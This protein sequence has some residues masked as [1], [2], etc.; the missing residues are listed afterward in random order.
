MTPKHE[1]KP[2]EDKLHKDNLNACV[3]CGFCLPA[4][5]TYLETGSEADSPRGRIVLMRGLHE[6]TLLPTDPDVVRHLDLCLGCRACEPACPSGVQ[7][8]H[9]LEYTRAQLHREHARPAQTEAARRAL[10]GV[11]T[12]PKAATIAMRFAQIGTGGQVPAL[13]V[14]ALSGD[15][16][17]Q[18]QTTTL[19]R[20]ISPP[21]PRVVTQAVG[22]RRYRVGLLTGCVMRVLYGDVNK[23]TVQVLAANGCEVLANRRQGCCGA[24]HAHQGQMGEAQAMARAL[25]DAFSP[26]GGL[27]A[28]IVNS[29]GCGSAMKAYGMLLAGDP[30]YATRAQ[31]FA[32]KVCDVCEFLDT[33]GWVAPF[34]DGGDET[35]VAYHDACH[36]AHGQGVPEAPRALLSRIPTVRLV[37]LAESEVCCGSAGIYNLT[38]PDMA[39]RLRVRKLDCILQT[40]AQVIAAGNPG[41]L[42]WIGAGLRD[43]GLPA[44]RAAHPVTLLAEALALAPGD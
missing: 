28:I 42:A 27:D 22:T 18:A 33:A 11:L 31:E 24:L 25:V 34:R 35:T 43:Q 8:G 5:P 16:D 10:L 21:L 41:C 20:Q 38:Q 17:A 13:A 36:L 4:C 15:K 44:V 39:L 29:A 1:N 23:D 32:A 30:A 7:Y 6:K 14:R 19:P 9:L 3:H 12:R 26:L 2:H 37:E 40:K